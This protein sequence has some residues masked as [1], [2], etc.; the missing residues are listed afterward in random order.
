MSSALA[1]AKKRRAF[2]EPTNNIVTPKQPSPPP[3]PRA[4][5]TQS[6]KPMTI[7]QAFKNMSDRINVLEEHA[8][9]NT[10]VPEELV[11]EYE[12]RFEMILNEIVNIKDT[13]IKLQTF[14]MEVNKSLHDQ[15]IKLLSGIDTPP[16]ITELDN[17]EQIF[18]NSSNIITQLSEQIQDVKSEQDEQESINGDDGDD[19]DDDDDNNTAEYLE[20]N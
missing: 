17:I 9:E 12:R 3:T 18:D 7:N 4:Q 5:N 1:A 10:G 14:S 20:E 16:N 8:T 6:D 15:R 2:G 19:G 13:L 11:E